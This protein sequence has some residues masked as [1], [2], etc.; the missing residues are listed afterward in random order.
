M[1]YYERN[2]EICK[3][4]SMEWY[5]QNRDHCITRMKVY[6]KQYYMENK[7]DPVDKIKQPEKRKRA[8]KSRQ[9]KKNIKQKEIKQ[10]PIVDD[11]KLTI[12]FD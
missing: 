7:Q 5:R 1:S 3:E 2:K 9:R 10:T 11:E 4:K 6:N 8:V 12:H